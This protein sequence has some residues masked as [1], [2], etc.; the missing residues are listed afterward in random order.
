MNPESSLTCSLEPNSGAHPDSNENS[1]HTKSFISKASTFL[2]PYR[3]L[4]FFPS[5]SP[6]RF[7]TFIT[8]VLHITP[9]PSS[10]FVIIFMWHDDESNLLHSPSYKY[11]ELCLFWWSQLRESNEWMTMKG[12]ERTWQNIQTEFETAHLVIR[13]PIDNTINNKLWEELAAD[14]PFIR[15]RPGIN[16]WRQLAVV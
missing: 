6:K 7:Y 10:S 8:C 16:C 15:Y 12:I 1:P 3:P 14:L 11:R 13:V 2:L 9:I 4:G 5:L